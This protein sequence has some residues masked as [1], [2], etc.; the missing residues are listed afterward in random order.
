[1]T[2]THDSAAPG[3]PS[4]GAALVRSGGLL[5]AGLVIF[6]V[7]TA[8]HPGQQPMND[9]TAVFAEYAA[10]RDWIPIHL[11]QFL[12]A[13]I[14]L[15]GLLALRRAMTG[16]EELL[17]ALALGAASATAAAIAANMAV[18]GVTLKHAVDAWAAAPPAEKSTRFAAAETV[19]W[20]EWGAN[21]FFQLLL[22]LTVGL[23]G[24]LLVRHRTTA[25]WIGLAGMLAGACLIW[26]A[27]T[28]AYD[29]FTDS[30]A[31]TVAAALFLSMALGILVQGLRRRATP[32]EQAPAPVP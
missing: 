25:R 5:L 15:C 31:S 10:S 19:R 4:T 3:Q 28:V 17:Q 9:H 12:A 27:V 14:V 22:G 11:A 6:E 16:H 26:A 20:L 2:R 29:G 23:F 8:L 32:S 21:S 18:D 30:P 7:A 13:L 1:M 24:L